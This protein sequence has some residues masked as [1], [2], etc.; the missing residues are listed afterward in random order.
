SARRD[1]A[2]Y[3][4]SFAKSA[5]GT[6]RAIDHHRGTSGTNERDAC[7]GAGFRFA[8]RRANA[9]GWS[10]R[11]RTAKSPDSQSDAGTEQG[12]GVRAEHSGRVRLIVAGPFG[13]GPSSS[14][15]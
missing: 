10:A 2:N 12:R 3:S 14:L 6:A 1:C 9:N 11:S 4:R 7:F 15:Q 5:K 13:G 8:Q